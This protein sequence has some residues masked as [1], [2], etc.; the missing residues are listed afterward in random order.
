VV[1]R[2]KAQNAF[3]RE[4]VSPVQAAIVVAI[5]AVGTFLTRALPF[6]LFPPGKKI[7]PFVAWLGKTL[8]FPIIGMLLVYCLKDVRPWAP[9]YGLPEL[10]AISAVTALYLLKRNSLIAIAGGTII[11]MVLVQGVFV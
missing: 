7:S 4:S 3:R 10:I 6:F 1:S 5:M 9:P 2:K 11:Y 8:P